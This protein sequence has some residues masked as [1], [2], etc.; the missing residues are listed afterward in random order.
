MDLKYVVVSITIALFSSLISIV[1]Q[2]FPASNEEFSLPLTQSVYLFGWLIVLWASVLVA[3]WSNRSFATR[4]KYGLTLMLAVFVMIFLSLVIGFS[5]REVAKAMWGNFAHMMAYDSRTHG[6]NVLD[7]R[8][9]FWI[10]HPSIVNPVCGTLMV[11]IFYSVWWP[12]R[13]NR[14]GVAIFAVSV[15]AYW[16]AYGNLFYID[17]KWVK[18]LIQCGR[19]DGWQFFLAFSAFPLATITVVSLALWLTPLRKSRTMAKYPV[20]YGWFFLPLGLAAAFSGVATFAFGPLLKAHGG[21]I[22]QIYGFAIAHASNGALLGVTFGLL[23]L[24]V[25]YRRRLGLK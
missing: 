7:D 22:S 17:R 19:S 6:D 25:K 12:R 3:F 18:T 23:V 10:A 20:M 2:I 16:G 9:R 11:V 21:T 13:W 24:T 5:L 4:A 14:Y 8:V 1:D 15:I